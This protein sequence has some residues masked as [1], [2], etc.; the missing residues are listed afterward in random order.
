MSPSASTSRREPV[1]RGI[2]GELRMDPFVNRAQHRARRRSR[3]AVAELRPFAHAGG[4]T[5]RR[6]HLPRHRP[7]PATRCAGSPGPPAST[8]S[9]ARATISRPRTRRR[10]RRISADA[11]ADEIVA[12]ALEGDRRRAHR[13]DRRDRRLLRLHPRRAK[14][15][16]AAPP[17]RRRAPAAADGAS[18][19]LVPARRTPCSTSSRRKAPIPSHTVLCHMNPLGDDVAYQTAS[20]RAAPS[21]NTT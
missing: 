10:S 5:R 11:I 8:S 13:P 12:E 7:Q 6:S 18:A 1:H 19:R 20:P 14:S 16:C 3:C 21:S 2:L 9:W 4:R 17:G 15:R